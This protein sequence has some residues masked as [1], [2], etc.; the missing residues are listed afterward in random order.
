M[1]RPLALFYEGFDVGGKSA[2]ETRKPGDLLPNNFVYQH[3]IDKI[4]KLQ[5]GQSNDKKAIEKQLKILHET[6][7][8]L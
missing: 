5:I 1:I 2:E 7:N 6:L 8:S 3:V 4:C